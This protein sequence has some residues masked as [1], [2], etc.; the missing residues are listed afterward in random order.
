MPHQNQFE[1]PP[2]PVLA[3]GTPVIM[4]YLRAVDAALHTK[5][6][7]IAGLR[8]VEFP[9]ASFEMEA[10]TSVDISSNDLTEIPYEIENM[11]NLERLNCSSNNI[12]QV[13]SSISK[14]PRLSFLDLRSNR[15]HQLPQAIKDCPAL[16][17]LLLD[18]NSFA[19]VS[20]AMLMAPALKL[21]SLA[22][23]FG[24]LV[25]SEHKALIPCCRQPDIRCR[26][27]RALR[28]QPPAAVPPAPKQ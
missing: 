15:L 23:P 27:H 1:D 11:R 3:Q 16:S 5:E 10:L 12:V 17:S 9:K 20:S 28:A 2:A 21:L 26:S 18:R 14:L 24:S 25:Y 4:Q 8:L 22:G 7:V 13:S 19:S 6:L